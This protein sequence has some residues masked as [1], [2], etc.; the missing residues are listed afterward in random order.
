MS[1]PRNVIEQGKSTRGIEFGST[2]IKAILIDEHY[3][4]IAAGGYQWEN[5][6]ENGFW[7]YH[8]DEIW[9]GLQACYSDL[10]HNVKESYGVSLNAVASL[11]F[12]GMMHGYL[13]FDEAGKL[14]V[15]FRTW[16]NT[17]TGQAA[18]ALTALFQ[19][20]IPLRW[21]IAHLY[22]VILDQEDYIEHIM[23]LTTLAGYVHWR[24]TG[25]KVMGI[26]EASGM[27]PIESQINDFDAKECELN[28]TIIWNSTVIPLR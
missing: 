16:R 15:P 1:D 20:N 24:L 27:F 4:P 6:Y 26:G 2:R 9:T 11:G 23:N 22:Q 3:A 14:L 19:F 10:R 5:R 7:T 8:E 25:E 17:T 12:S 21:S 13:P 18:E 28:K